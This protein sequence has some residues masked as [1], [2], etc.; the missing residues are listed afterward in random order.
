VQPLYFTSSSIF[1]SPNFPPPPSPLP[2]QEFHA[3]VIAGKSKMRE[4]ERLL[5]NLKGLDLSTHKWKLKPT[6]NEPPLGALHHA[7]SLGHWEVVKLLLENGASQKIWCEQDIDLQQIAQ[8]TCKII[9]AEV[10]QKSPMQNVA[11]R[12]VLPLTL[13]EETN[14]IEIR[15]SGANQSI[16]FES[17][18]VTVPGV[19][20]Y[21]VNVKNQGQG[22]QVGWC[23]DEFDSS[24]MGTGNSWTFDCHKQEVLTSDSKK[25]PSTQV[26]QNDY[27]VGCI[28]DTKRHS[29]SF[30]INGAIFQAFT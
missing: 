5:P 30:S 26:S 15:S 27:V 21:E 3:A 29:I 10:D 16:I 20:L 18:G 9:S 24:H 4:L 25:Q 2:T 12:D 23:S 19:F 11:D 8:L 6:S 13:S 17:A 7:S 1:S 22:L 28:V 14:T